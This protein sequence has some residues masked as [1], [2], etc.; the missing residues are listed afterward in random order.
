MPR[1]AVPIAVL[2]LDA[3]CAAEARATLDAAGV[4]PSVATVTEGPAARERG[5]V[6]FVASSIGDL[7]LD[8]LASSPDRDYLLVDDVADEL[9]VRVELLR[10]RSARRRSRREAAEKLRDSAMQLTWAIH[11]A[12]TLD[13]LAQTA[14][15]GVRE[16]MG[17]HD[18]LLVIP[19]GPDGAKDPIPNVSWSARDGRM[20]HLGELIAPLMPSCSTRDPNER[21][22]AAPR[23]DDERV[24]TVDPAQAPELQRHLFAGAEAGQF[25]VVPVDCDDGVTGALV[26][27][28]P[29]TAHRTAFERSLLAYIGIQIG[30]AA[31]EL[32]LRDRERYAREQLNQTS[33]ELQR[34]LD[35]MD[36]LGVVIR[37]IADAVNVGV[38]FYDTENHPKL[39]NRTVETFLA[40]AGFDPVTGLSSHVY[41]SDRRTR[42]KQDKNIISETIEG[43]QRGLIYWIGDPE[44][45]QRAIITEA[46]TIARPG[47]ERLGSA[48]VTYDVT[49]LANAIEIREEYLATVSHEL[50]TPLT[51]IVG[52]LDLIADSHDVEALGFG[53]EFRTIQRSAEQMLTLIRDL[54]STSTHD[55]ALRIE[56]TDVSTLLTQS[57][58]AF[59]PALAESHQKLEL[60]A[61]QGTVL[62][63]VDAGRVKQVV[64]NLISNAL[65]YSPESGVITVT[66][67][68]DQ[69]SVIIAVADNGRGI[70][71]SDQV[72]LFDRF[73]RTR[74]VREAAIQGVGIGLTI[75]KA[76]V[77]AHGGTI[78]VQSE[79]GHGSTFTVRLPLRSEATPLSNLPMQP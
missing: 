10:K 2:A 37:S 20:P 52:Y 74:E 1:S 48:V 77:D 78:S 76:I 13:A 46:H 60:H 33:S 26:V 6:L 5:P 61:P 58:S 59:R 38:L 43:D 53:K 3:T 57:V 54:L 65:K 8:A 14:T 15:G 25:T 39:H 4:A 11:M 69:T 21:W 9:V 66:L 56:P 29:P 49:D 70:S 79:P 55:L 73:F 28:D 12:E 71:K 62:A 42:V 27:A 7:P 30:R 24:A 68:R 41:A 75:V 23:L 45:E 63:H 47:G 40:L 67:D 17:A 16:L 32:W 34:L 19:S 36:E 18:A 44:G 72:R 31:S 22:T 64:D 35:E 50:R 51:S